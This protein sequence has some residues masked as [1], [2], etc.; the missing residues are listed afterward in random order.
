LEFCGD[1]NVANASL[2]QAPRTQDDN[3]MTAVKI[4]GS[5]LAFLLPAL[6]AG[7]SM[8]QDVP[9]KLLPPVG[10]TKIGTY[11]GKGVQIYSCTVHDTVPGWTLKA[12]EAQ[13]TDANGAVFAKHY[14]GPTWEAADGSK[15][16]GKMMETVPSP[17]AGAVPWLLLS[18]TSSGAGILSG[19]RFV[20]RINTAGGIAPSG[21]CPE[22]GAEQRVP[23]SADYVF[24][25]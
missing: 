16:V 17:T 3:P 4:F 11:L 13:L 5:T 22:P 19:T 2:E 15:A 1:S 9:A 20:Q 12:P 14:A 23:Y 18:A 7:A 24:Y 8:A 6:L 25:R 10:V 21:A